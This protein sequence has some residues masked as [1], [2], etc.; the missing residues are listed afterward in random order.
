MTLASARFSQKRETPPAPNATLEHTHTHA[1]SATAAV[2]GPGNRRAKDHVRVDHLELEPRAER[3]P[4]VLGAGAVVDH[5]LE[6]GRL[7]EMVFLS[8]GRWFF[9]P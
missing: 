3:L 2:G 9:E 6:L 8:C 7:R 4:Q 5:D 1:H